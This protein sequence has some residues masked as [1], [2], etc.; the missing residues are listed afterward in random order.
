M[1]NARNVQ[2][3]LF[4]RGACVEWIEVQ[5]KGKK[6]PI[7][8]YKN[9]IDHC[10]KKLSESEMGT[11]L[12]MLTRKKEVMLEEC[13]FPY[14]YDEMLNELIIAYKECYGKQDKKDNKRL[15][16]YTVS[17][18]QVEGVLEQYFDF[19]HVRVDSIFAGSN[20]SDA[21]KIEV[22]SNGLLYVS[23]SAVE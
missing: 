8:L 15:P 19:K 1:Y 9:I 3:V 18:N 12:E 10:S 11:V 21:T 4:C 22:G 5:L 6:E 14:I 23:F 13:N 16:Q 20:D 17:I 2:R 7:S